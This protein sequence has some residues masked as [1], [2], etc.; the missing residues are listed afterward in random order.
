MELEPRSARAVERPTDSG[1]LGLVL[2]VLVG[3]V[4][5]LSVLLY[6][7]E[8]RKTRGAASASSAVG[9]DAGVVVVGDLDDVPAS[10]AARAAEPRGVKLLVPEGARLFVD[11]HALP[12]GTVEVQ[13]P[14]SGV[15]N[16]LVKAEGRHDTLVLVDPQAPEEM[17][18][19]MPPA[20]PKRATPAATIVMP[21]NPYE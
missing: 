7:H 1:F 19:T 16:V 3:A 13:R 2:A 9:R 20:R 8:V 21:P 6:V 15:L 17:K 5:G 4:L 11:G 12:E 10:S 18:I 14:D